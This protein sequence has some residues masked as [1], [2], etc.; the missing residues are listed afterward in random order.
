MSEIISQVQRFRAELLVKDSAAQQRLNRVWVQL[1]ERLTGELIS[2]L[3]E[4]QRNGV[5]SPS[6]LYQV[7]RFQTLLTQIDRELLDFNAQAVKDLESSQRSTIEASYWSSLSWVQQRAA[8][9]GIPFGGSVG[10]KFDRMNPLAVEA[11]IGILADG[12]PVLQVLEEV[13]LQSTA[14]LVAQMIEGIARGEH[15]MK[16]ARDLVNQGLVRDLQRVQSIMRTEFLRASREATLEGY[17][18]S[19]VVVGYQRMSALSLRSCI[20]CIVTHGRKYPLSVPFEE[21]TN[22]RCYPVPVLDWN[23]TN[24]LLDAQEW[25]DNL[26]PTDQGKIL[27]PGSFQLYQQ[28]LVNFNQLASRRIDPVWGNSI[29]PTTVGQLQ[30]GGGGIPSDAYNHT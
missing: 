23:D 25:F 20:G 4:L 24:P 11:M 16:L 30:I 26:S 7:Q 17:R 3:E 13:A 2:L 8:E 14:L 5:R 29:V 1:E 22:G 15:P 28:G 18:R 21:H 19:G 9:M 10:V 27:P 6:Q 12:S